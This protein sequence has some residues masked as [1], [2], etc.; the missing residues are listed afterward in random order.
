M[1]NTDLIDNG[2]SA[3]RQ[4]NGDLLIPA[5]TVQFLEESLAQL[6]RALSRTQ[7]QECVT[8]GQMENLSETANRQDF[9]DKLSASANIDSPTVHARQ[10]PSTSSMADNSESLQLLRALSRLLF[11]DSSR[12]PT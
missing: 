8:P 5:Q 12:G 7:G 4:P 6:E 9:V 1:P 10:L 3:M 2:P 11:S